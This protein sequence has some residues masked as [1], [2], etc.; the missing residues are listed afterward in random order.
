MLKVAFTPWYWERSGKGAA[1]WWQKQSSWAKH[2]V[3]TVD[4]HC[5]DLVSMGDVSKLGD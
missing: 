4:L 5:Q 1:V 2:H 3:I